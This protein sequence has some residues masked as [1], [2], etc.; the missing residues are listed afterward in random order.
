MSANDRSRLR[1]LSRE[2]RHR[3]IRRRVSGTEQRPRV[4][5]FRSSKHIYA[6]IVDDGKR[7]TLF[8]VDSTSKE[9]KGRM[10]GKKGKVAAAI[11]C[12]EILA[13]KAKAKGITAVCFDRGGYLYHGRVKALAE[14]ARNAG[15]Q[16]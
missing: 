1:R 13:E 14:A 15:L 8:A 9:V 7:R 3:R 11:A 2:R 10:D 5:V 12:G 6:Q 4:A 16:F